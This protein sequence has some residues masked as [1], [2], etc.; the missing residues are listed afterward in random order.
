MMKTHITLVGG[1]PIPVYLGIQYA[2]ADEVLFIC[3]NQ[4]R[5]EAERVDAEIEV[6]SEIIEL[7]PVDLEKIVVEVARLAESL[8]DNEV[9]INISSGTKPWAYYFASIFAQHPNTTLFYIDQNNKV[10][11]LTDQTHQNIELDMDVRFRLHGNP[12]ENFHHIGKYVAEDFEAIQAIREIRKFS[13]GDFTQLVNS[14][15]KRTNLSVHSTRNGSTLEWNKKDKEFLIR[16]YNHKGFSQAYVLESPHIY[17]LIHNTG[18][19][20]L[21]LAQLLKQ[22]EYSREVRL[23]CIFP[24]KANSPKNEIDIIIDTGTKLLFVECKTQ[25]NSETDIDKFAAAVKVYGGSGSKALFVTDAPMRDKAK[26]KCNDNGVLSFSL[27]EYGGATLSK[28][29][30]FELLEKE[31]FNINP[32]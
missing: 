16:L 17:R 10:W 27:E 7:D 18:W 20:E 22:W 26:E 12:L 6:S 29:P 11:N 4:T 1:Q 21:E 28:R 19:F 13:P 24:T 2:K 3:S 15:S 25:I 23:N 5:N 9:S 14:F 31:L 32:K 8:Q 30:L